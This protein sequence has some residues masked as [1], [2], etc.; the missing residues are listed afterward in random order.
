MGQRHKDYSTMT[1]EG[2]GLQYGLGLWFYKRLGF[3]LWYK[4]YGWVFPKK[5]HLCPVS[6]FTGSEFQAGTL[7]TANDLPPSVIWTNTHLQWFE[8]PQIQNNHID[9]NQNSQKI[10]LYYDYIF[11]YTYFKSIQ[12]STSY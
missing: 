11:I 3:G 10:N 2:L 5:T 6:V 8:T 1:W 7:L 9:H 4:G 12:C